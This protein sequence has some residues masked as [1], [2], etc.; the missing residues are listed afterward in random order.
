MKLTPSPRPTPIRTASDL[1]HVSGV[2]AI[3]AA[4]VLARE[5][6]SPV[7]RTLKLWGDD[8]NPFRHLITAK[9]PEAR[10]WRET[11][12]ILIRHLAPDTP[13]RTV[14]RGWHF[15]TGRARDVLM[16]NLEKTGRFT[17]RRVGMSASQ[18][19][20]V[21]I[22]PAFLN[23]HGVLWE[24]RRPSSARNLAPIFRAIG[25]KYPEQREMVF[26]AGTIFRLVRPPTWLNLH[27]S[28]QTLRVRHHVLEETR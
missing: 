27:R 3:A 7:T 22:R 12:G 2:S 17:N 11:M 13:R 6:L 21:A 19:R 14:W 5:P 1:L 24:I 10:F 4:K 18:L 25:A 28:G 20:R 16:R 23:Q 9:S 8:E 15:E 26:P